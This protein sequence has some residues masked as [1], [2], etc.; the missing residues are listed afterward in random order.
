MRKYR[1]VKWW[2]IAGLL[3]A[4]SFLN[5]CAL[6]PEG[7]EGGGIDWI[8]IGFIVVI[9]VAFYFLLIR[10]QQKRQKQHQRLIEELKRGDMV[11]TSGGI[12]GRIEN[13]GDDSVVLKVES[14][15]TIRVARNSVTRKR[16]E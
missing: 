2:L 13:V 9:F 16:G 12:F 5:G 4:I 7:E 10:P 3:S 15:A 1:S 8:F 6:A 14:G 11:V